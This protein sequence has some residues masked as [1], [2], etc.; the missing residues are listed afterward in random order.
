MKKLVLIGALLATTLPAHA[1]NDD[2]E[3][4]VQMI[5]A[6]MYAATLVY[7]EFCG[8]L[9]PQ[10]KASLQ[11]YVAM[12]LTRDKVFQVLAGAVESYNENKLIYCDVLRDGMSK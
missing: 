7:E 11:Q 2:L 3:H 1:L 12:G 8:P 9:G 6:K 4:Q 5:A 10:T